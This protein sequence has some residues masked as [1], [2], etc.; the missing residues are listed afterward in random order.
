MRCKVCGREND[1]SSRFCVRCGRTL[2][3]SKDV[4]GPGRY[5]LNFFI[6]SFIG[7]T[8]TFFLRRQGWLATW[9]SLGVAVVAV[10]VIGV[11]TV[12]QDGGADQSS[13][14]DLPSNDTSADDITG[15]WST[16]LAGDLSF[17]C[18]T[19]Y[20]QTGTSLAWTQ[21][22]SEL[23]SFSGTGTINPESG[24]F[25]MTSS[26]PAF[27]PTEGS[28]SLDGSALSG[29]WDASEV[30]FS[31]TFTA[32]RLS[33]SATLSTRLCDV[34]IDV[35][36]GNIIIGG[37]GL[38]VDERGQCAVLLQSDSAAEG[39]PSVVD[40]IEVPLVEAVGP[41]T[42]QLTGVGGTF[43]LVLLADGTIEGHV[44]ATGISTPIEGTSGF[45]VALV[46]RAYPCQSM[47]AG[48]NAIGIVGSGFDGPILGDGILKVDTIVDPI[49]V[50][51]A[52][53]PFRDFDAIR[54][55]SIFEVTSEGL[56]IRLGVVACSPVELPEGG[57]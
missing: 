15:T 31:G 57:E 9:I 8:L 22:C 4:V 36:P 7:L 48:G 6:A 19:V 34:L 10:V 28:V 52:Q 43:L 27:P 16:T 44:T 37:E 38:T 11:V 41:V 50:R 53:P 5:I 45:F 1:R 17:S 24:T 54:A 12:A 56:P 46:H 51:P 21:E 35:L 14:T 18:T 25:A 32:T 47:E 20:L 55:V 26:N 23:F 29:T 2:S 49:F 40:G 30:G 3:E 39:S 33:S 13:I 42:G